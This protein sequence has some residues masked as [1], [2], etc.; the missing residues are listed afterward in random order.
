MTLL[1]LKGINKSYDRSIL[2][3]LNLTVGEGEY[4]SIIGTS[5]AGKSTLMNIIGLIEPFDNGTYRFRGQ[6]IGTER[7]R[8]YVRQN[9][10]GFI[11][12]SFHLLPTLNVRE[13]I[14]LPCQYSAKKPQSAD[15]LMDRLQIK[16]LLHQFPDQLSGGERQRVAICR[17]LLLQP[18]LLLADEPTGNLD[19][20]NRDRVLLIIDEEHQ[21]GKAVII[22]T[23]DPIVAQRAQRQLILE[24]GQFRE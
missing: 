14:Y 10:I 13:N 15:R 7:K 21:Q 16:H 12:Q 18:S 2:R 3:G 8:C 24:G 17:A 19:S 22:I 9:E 11:F 6:T 1:D 20:E 23:H 4:V 5:G